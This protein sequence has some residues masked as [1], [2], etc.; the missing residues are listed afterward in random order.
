MAE[1][2]ISASHK[3]TNPT[4]QLTDEAIA[5]FRNPER[6]VACIVNLGT[7][8]P[9]PSTMSS[10]NLAEMTSLA[11]DAERV[12]EEFRRR[13]GSQQE[14][15]YR[16][17]MVHCASNLDSSRPHHLSEVVTHCKSYLATF[18]VKDI[19]TRVVNSLHRPNITVTLQRLGKLSIFLLP[20]EDS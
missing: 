2:F 1:N 16:L 11:G 13:C 18:A 20:L 7:G 5:A 3:Y 10:M 14:I 15:F 17:S 8:H 4:Y 12:A 19:L 9:G 6:S